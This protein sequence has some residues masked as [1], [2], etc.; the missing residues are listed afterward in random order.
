[1]DGYCTWTGRSGANY[2]F[3]V[4]RIATTTFNPV[5]C[6]YILAIQVGSMW[7]TVHVGQTN[8]L[9]RRIEEHKQNGYHGAT[10][11]HVFN[12]DQIPQVRLLIEKDLGG[13]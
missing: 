6:N 10:H 13:G 1:M 2:Q 11:V 9:K 12:K 4:W 7:R 3:E 8:D 5:A